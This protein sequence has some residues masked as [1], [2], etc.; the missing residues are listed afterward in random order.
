MQSQ[1]PLD[2]SMCRLW[3]KARECYRPAGEVVNHRQAAVGAID[4][5]TLKRFVVDNHYSA[6]F[7]ASRL[8]VGLFVKKRD[9]G[10]TLRRQDGFLRRMAHPCNFSFTWSFGK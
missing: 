5:A 6:S 3:R 8:S 4:V 9:A 10:A 2:F 1:F 7:P